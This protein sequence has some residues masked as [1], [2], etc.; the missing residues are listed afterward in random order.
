MLGARSDTLKIYFIL[1]M[2]SFIGTF[3]IDWKIILAQAINFFV[4]LIILYFLVLKPLRKLMAEREQTITGGLDNA[5]QNAELLSI[6]KKEY[7]AVLVKARAE[8][9]EIFQ[10]GKQEAE[11]KKAEMMESAKADVDSMIAN[12]KKALEVQKVKMVEEAKQEI[13]SLVVRATEKLL[14]GEA[15]EEFDAKAVKEIKKIDK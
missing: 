3:H 4:V 12:G 15:D 7:D 13:V 6:T 5:K 8:A 14:G 1:H 11:I 9:H 2:D 10:A